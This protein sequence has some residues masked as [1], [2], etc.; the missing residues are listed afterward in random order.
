MELVEFIDEMAEVTLVGQVM[1]R[2][3]YLES[4][5][6]DRTGA[7]LM[8]SGEDHYLYQQTLREAYNNGWT[9]DGSSNTSRGNDT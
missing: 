1:D 5:Y 3:V 9:D 4:V 6:D 2:Q 7:R 8:L